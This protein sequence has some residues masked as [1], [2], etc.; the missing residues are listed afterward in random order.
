[1]DSKFDLVAMTGY[2]LANVQT[3]SDSSSLSATVSVMTVDWPQSVHA[4]TQPP[5]PR[6]S[7]KLELSITMAA[8]RAGNR[9]K[10]NVCLVFG[11]LLTFEISP[12]YS[13][14]CSTRA[15]AFTTRPCF[16][17]HY[18]AHHVFS[19]SQNGG[20]TRLPHL[21]QDLRPPPW[22]PPARLDLDTR[23]HRQIDRRL[24]TG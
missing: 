2:E 22:L 24:S 18:G 10:S 8:V 14:F 19:G 9:G 13:F 12:T 6:L 21:R 20:S 23:V 11:S 7:V 1:M 4:L 3:S 15:S 16:L 5:C 17:W